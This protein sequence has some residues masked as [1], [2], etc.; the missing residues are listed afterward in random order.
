MLAKPVQCLRA[1]FDGWPAGSGIVD[2]VVAAGGTDELRRSEPVDDAYTF[3][4]EQTLKRRPQRGGIDVPE[5]ALAL[6]EGR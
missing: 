5:P 6:H 4:A 2:R 1:H 3:I